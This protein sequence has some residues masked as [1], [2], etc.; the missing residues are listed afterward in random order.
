MGIFENENFYHFDVLEN[1]EIFSKIIIST[2]YN[3]FP[4][5]KSRDA[6]IFHSHFDYFLWTYCYICISFNFDNFNIWIR[7]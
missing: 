2:Y 7:S 3:F 6:S 1:F 4:F 5:L